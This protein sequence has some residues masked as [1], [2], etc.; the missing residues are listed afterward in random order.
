MSRRR[1]SKSTGQM[2]LRAVNEERQAILYGGISDKDEMQVFIIL[3][4]ESE[5][6]F[7][8]DRSAEFENA[9]DATLVTFRCGWRNTRKPLPIFRSVVVRVLVKDVRALRDASLAG[10]A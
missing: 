6:T 4:P 8:L 3:A 1:T 5:R 9:D 10:K 7:Q 2:D